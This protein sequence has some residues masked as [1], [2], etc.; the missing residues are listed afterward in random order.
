MRSS[1]QLISRNISDGIFLRTGKNRADTLFASTV[2]YCDIEL[3]PYVYDLELAGQ[4]LDEAGWKMGSGNVR[5]KDGQPL[6]I[7]LLYNSDSVTE[8][9]LQSIF[10]ANT[11]PS[12]FL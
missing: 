2:P 4:I 7:D 11:S 6:N 5:E 10:R 8:N 1:M 12:V 9:P 3:E